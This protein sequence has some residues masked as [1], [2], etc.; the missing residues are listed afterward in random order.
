MFDHV[1]IRAGDAAASERFY[2]T[3]LE[4]LPAGEWRTDLRIEQAAGDG[5][6]TGDGVTRHLHIAFV[7]TSREQVDGFWRA[8]VAAGYE[9]AGDPG[10]RTTYSAT[11]YGGF[12]LDPDGNSAEAVHHGREREPGSTIDHLWIGV[13]DLSAALAFWETV[14]PPLELKVY[15]HRP[16]RFHVGA[17]DRSFALVAD[18]RPATSNLELGVQVSSGDA[19]RMMREAAVGGGWRAD[20]DGVFDADGNRVVPVAAH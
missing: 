6:A 8:G 14:A 10:P 7:T 20:G 17:R 18:G 16:E 13:T 11:Y 19:A 5:A 2:A 3:V 9:S 1:S 4:G 12:L 15:G